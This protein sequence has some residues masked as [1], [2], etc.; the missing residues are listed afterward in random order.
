MNGQKDGVVVLKPGPPLLGT[1]SALCETQPHIFL[2]Q[3]VRFNGGR[4]KIMVP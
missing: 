4:S 3:V 2:H 1:G